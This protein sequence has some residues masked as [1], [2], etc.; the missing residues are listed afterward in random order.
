MKK[1]FFLAALVFTTSA[2]AQAIIPVIRLTP[3]P[4]PVINPMPDPSTVTKDVWKQAW[5]AANTTTAT[6]D[7]FGSG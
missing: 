1:I 6:V 3:Q 4:M 2:F 5:I 7:L